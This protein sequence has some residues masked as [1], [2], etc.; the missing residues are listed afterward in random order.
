MKII[1]AVRIA[2]TNK[3]S[4]NVKVPMGHT[5]VLGKEWVAVTGCPREINYL[6]L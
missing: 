6:S 2:L 5:R 3:K 1:A 4:M